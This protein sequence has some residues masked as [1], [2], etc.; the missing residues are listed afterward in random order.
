MKILELDREKKEAQVSRRELLPDPWPRVP[1]LYKAGGVYAGVVSGVET[2]PRRDANP[3][4]LLFVR[5][6]EGVDLAA[7]LPPFGVLKR[8][9][10]VS[11]RVTG[12]D[13]ERR[14]MYGRIV[15]RHG[16]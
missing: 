3:V 16:A 6:A 13:P 7:K 2:F 14:R 8:G 10:R 5:L 11:V 1:E 4:A 12:I 15:G 9:D